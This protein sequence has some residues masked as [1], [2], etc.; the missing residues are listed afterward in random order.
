MLFGSSFKEALGMGLGA[1]G[2]DVEAENKIKAEQ[3]KQATKFAYDVALD[4]AKNGNKDGPKFD[5]KSKRMNIG[6][7]ENPI[8]ATMT[9]DEAGKVYYATNKLNGGKPFSQSDLDKY[10]SLNPLKINTNPL[11]VHTKAQKNTEQ[12]AN[13]KNIQTLMKSNVDKYLQ[14]DASDQEKERV[15]SALLSSVGVNEAFQVLRDNGINTDFNYINGSGQLIM[16]QAA[17]DILSNKFTKKT[18]AIAVRDRITMTNFA[19]AKVPSAPGSPPGSLP[20]NAYVLATSYNPDKGSY[21]GE[22]SDLETPGPIPDEAWTKTKAGVRRFFKNLAGK[23]ANK[24]SF[25]NQVGQ[26]YQFFN[27]WELTNGFDKKSGERTGAAKAN[28]VVALEKGYTPFQ[29]W[30]QKEQK[31]TKNK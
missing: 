29:W 7:E 23:D 8:V 18:L 27:Q 15:N 22:G 24:T 1:V 14:T 31:I 25:N 11:E 19:N 21:L 16:Q 2:A 4:R 30:I 6:T 3:A 17:Q 12:R 13:I 28:F 5:K 26:S 20:A 10:S 9:V